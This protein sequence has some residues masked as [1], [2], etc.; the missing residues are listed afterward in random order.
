[1]LAIFLVATAATAAP[2]A[3]MNAARLLS[4][5]NGAWAARARP[6]FE[7]EPVS[8]KI[9]TGLRACSGPSL[10]VT[11]GGG[12]DRVETVNLVGSVGTQE[13]SGR[14][15]TAQA[16][17][18]ALTAPG[19]PVRLA[20]TADRLAVGDGRAAEAQLGPTCMRVSLSSSRLMITTFSRRLCDVDSAPD[21]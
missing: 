2:V 21:P 16:I 11:L 15:L 9:A 4:E 5:F 13:L 19:A 18:I 6:A 7:V 17:L 8:T 12:P 1:M 14:Y 3:P 20:V 10:C